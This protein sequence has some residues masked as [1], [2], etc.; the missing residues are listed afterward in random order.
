MVA[1]KKKTKN[2]Q[3]QIPGTRR[4]KS[5]R[6]EGRCYKDVTQG[7]CMLSRSVVSN[8]FQP[9]GL[10]PNRLLCPWNSPDRSTEVG[11]HFLFQGIFPTQ[12]LNPCLLYLLDWQ[13]GS[14]PL[15]PPGKRPQRYWFWKTWDS[16]KTFQ[17][18]CSFRRNKDS[19]ELRWKFEM[20]KKNMQK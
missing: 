17:Y 8:S 9:H 6:N 18:K 15:A 12:R 5:F 11:Y 2:Q 13:A 7:T 4:K 10:Q 3:N 19:K 1:K 20:K 14:L 16:M